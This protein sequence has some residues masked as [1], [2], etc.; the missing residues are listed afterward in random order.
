[1]RQ[2]QQNG[3]KESFEKNLKTFTINKAIELNLQNEL[4]CFKPNTQ[5]GVL[6]IYPF[7]L[8]KY[9]LTNDSKVQRLI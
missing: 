9:Q 7:D 3:D 1:L 2:K 4:G 6:L 8:K 5:P